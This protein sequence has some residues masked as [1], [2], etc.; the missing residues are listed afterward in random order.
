MPFIKFM[1]NLFFKKVSLIALQVKT[2][3]FRPEYLNFLAGSFVIE[4]NR[5]QPV[6]L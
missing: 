2:I 5:L 4:E 3:L 6:V 1:V